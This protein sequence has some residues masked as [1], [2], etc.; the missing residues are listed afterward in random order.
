MS[1][2][3]P[4]WMAGLGTVIT[5]IAQEPGMTVYAIS[6]DMTLQQPKP[7]FIAATSTLEITADT[8]RMVIGRAN[9]FSI[10]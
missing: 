10:P 6:G 7:S 9:G 3:I 1:G 2:W 4:F 8:E 5:G